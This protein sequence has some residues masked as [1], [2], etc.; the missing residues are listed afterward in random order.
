MREKIHW[1]QEDCRL[2]HG[3]NWSTLISTVSSTCKLSKLLVYYIS[4]IFMLKNTCLSLSLTISFFR[5]LK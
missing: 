4:D 5:I 1:A 3:R 2:K